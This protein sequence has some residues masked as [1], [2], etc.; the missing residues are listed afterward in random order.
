MVNNNLGYRCRFADECPI[1]LGREAYRDK[2]LHIVR[3]VFCNRGMKGWQNCERFNKLTGKN[4]HDE[5]SSHG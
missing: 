2:P 1:F 3:N 5:D 4:Q